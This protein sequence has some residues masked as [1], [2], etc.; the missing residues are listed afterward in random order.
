[1]GVSNRAARKFTQTQVAEP[2]GVCPRV[3]T[4]RENGEE[5]AAYSD[6]ALPKKQKE[7]I[8][9]GIS[10][11]TDCES[12]MQWHIEQAAGAGA[13]VQCNYASMRVNLIRI[14]NSR[15]IR[16]PKPLLE[17]AGLR[18]A[19]QLRAEPGR[20]VILPDRAARQGWEEQFA[21]STGG[22]D[23]LALLS[24]ITNTFDRNE[25]TW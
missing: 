7:L 5:K 2:L 8:V 13:G 17:Q 21:G 9:V 24:G 25:W 4:R 14:G 6:G 20:L 19:V 23:D 18:D 16:I 10:V 3:H 22:E 11:V 12:C 15:G 1:M